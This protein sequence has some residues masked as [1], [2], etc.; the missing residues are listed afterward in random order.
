[1]ID[2]KLHKQPASRVLLSLTWGEVISENAHPLACSR[3]ISTTKKRQTVTTYTSC[4][5]HSCSELP[6]SEYSWI[7]CAGNIHYLIHTKYFCKLPVMNHKTWTPPLWLLRWTFVDSFQ[8]RATMT[9]CS[10][11]VDIHRVSGSEGQLM[12]GLWIKKKV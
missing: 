1:M 8:Q 4:V 9:A 5:C 6:L 7:L 10:P 11:G 12:V 2:D 3:H